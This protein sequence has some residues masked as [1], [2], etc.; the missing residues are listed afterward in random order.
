M[1]YNCCDK[2]LTQKYQLLNC[3]EVIKVYTTATYSFL[4][5]IFIVHGIVGGGGG[6]GNFRLPFGSLWILGCV[7]FV[8]WVLQNRV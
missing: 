1:K 5:S 6:G 8:N 7:N 3:M 4:Q 2:N